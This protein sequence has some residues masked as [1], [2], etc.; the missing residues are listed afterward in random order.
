MG[1]GRKA[2]RW[3]GANLSN[4]AIDSQLM[5]RTEGDANLKN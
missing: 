1:G 2:A 3:E 5:G 4:R